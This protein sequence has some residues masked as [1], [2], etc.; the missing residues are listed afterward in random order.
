MLLASSTIR[1]AIPPYSISSPAK[2]K[3]GMAR[4]E[5]TVIPDTMRPKM[6]PTGRPS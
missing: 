5:N 3:N 1:W 4:N 2:M 6:T